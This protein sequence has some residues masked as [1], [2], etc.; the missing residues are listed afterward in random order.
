VFRER[1]RETDHAR[2]VASHIVTQRR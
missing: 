1:V 2:V